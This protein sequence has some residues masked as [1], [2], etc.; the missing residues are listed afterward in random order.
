MR[1][2]RKHDDEHDEPDDGS[3][4]APIVADPYAQLDEPETP[5][6]VYPTEEHEREALAHVLATSPNLTTYALTR[7]V[8]ER[9]ADNAQRA[10]RRQRAATSTL[11]DEHA[12]V[13]PTEAHVLDLREAIPGL[14][15][16]DEKAVMRAGFASFLASVDAREPV[17]NPTIDEE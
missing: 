13:F 8:Q 17:L 2:A 1:R 15:N 9:L 12:P 6:P 10:T 14:T 5:A 16:D 11:V 4:P 3:A 7:A